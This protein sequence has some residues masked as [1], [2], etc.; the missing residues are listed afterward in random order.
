[1]QN[2]SLIETKRRNGQSV[3]EFRWRDRTSGKAVYRRIVLG[4]VEQFKTEADARKIAEGIVLEI[5]SGDPRLGTSVLT[6]SQLIE[7]YRR[8]E[9]AVDNNWK[10]YATK[11]G[12]ENY[13]KRWIAPKWGTYPLTKIKPIE[14]ESWL[15]QIPLARG[16]C[17][18]IRNI[19]SVLFN[20]ACRYELYSENPIHLVRQSAKRRRV[21]P[22]L[23]IDEIKQLLDN[24]AFLPRLL[25]FLD[26]TTGLRQSELFGLRWSDLDFDSGEINVVRSVVHGVISRCKTESSSKPIPMTP[27]LAEMLKEWRKVTRFP[28][29]DDWVF[30][31][32]RAKGRRPI[33]GQS[34]MRKQIH[35]AVEKLRIQKRIGWHTFRH[36]YSSLLRHLGTDIKVQQDLLRH[37]SARLTLDTYTQ[38]VT[39]AKREAQ[40]AVVKLLLS[41]EPGLLPAP[42]TSTSI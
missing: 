5:N 38:A 19:M 20:H 9:L 8:R 40:N 18:K 14:V 13:L 24:V 16:S 25:I 32:K 35:P 29:L 27:I 39:P 31:S 6:M 2:G 1:M 7:H 10:S 15:R 17:A 33:W 21:P 3:W 34:I 4:T 37:S 30:A 11:M 41:V 26:V 22:I 28:S 42:T 23:H 12:Y 36:S